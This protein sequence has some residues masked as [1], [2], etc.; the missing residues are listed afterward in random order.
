ME[1]GPGPLGYIG[2]KG[3]SCRDSIGSLGCR[4]Y[5]EN[6]LLSLGLRALTM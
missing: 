6:F 3:S 5:C 4:G 1:R 2:T